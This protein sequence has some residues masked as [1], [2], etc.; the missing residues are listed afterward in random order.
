MKGAQGRP[1]SG[2]MLAGMEQGGNEVW[3]LCTVLAMICRRGS[4][5]GWWP[6]IQAML[7]WKGHGR[8]SDR[9]TPLYRLAANVLWT[10]EHSGPS[11]PF[12]VR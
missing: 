6:R 12:S 9:Q 10:N 8:A 1:F 7:W 5:S 2:Y 11:V 3:G 4:E